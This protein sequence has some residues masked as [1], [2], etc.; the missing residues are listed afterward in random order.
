MATHSE[1]QPAYK[2]LKI[3]ADTLTPIGIFQRLHGVR[4]FLLESSFEHDKKGRYSYIGSDPYE[5]IIGYGD[6]TTIINH[7]TGAIS[8]Y[9]KNALTYLQENFPKL[10]LDLPL[11]FTGG[12]IGYI[13]YD[14]IRQF[15][16]IGTHLPDDL[17]MPDIH[18]MVYKNLI[19]YE[20]YNQTVSLV[21]INMDESNEEHLTNRLDS[22][23]KVLHREVNQSTA[24]VSDL[25]FESDLTDGDF[26]NRVQLAKDYIHQG[27]A[28]QIVLSKRMKSKITGNPLSY[29]RKLRMANPSPY[30]FYIDFKDYVIIGASPESLIQTKGTQVITNPIAGTRPRGKTKHDDAVLKAELLADKKE[31]AEHEMLVSLSKDELTQI[32]DPDSMTTPTYMNVEMYQHVMHIVSEVHGVLK[33]DQTSLDALIASLPAGTV[34]GSPKVR[35]MQIINELEDTK[36]GFYG[37]GIGYINFNHD[38]NMALAIRSLIIKADYAYLQTGAGI[39][40]DSNPEDEFHETLHKAR[41]LMEVNDIDFVL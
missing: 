5:E 24:E 28:L 29:Y 27:D 22:L 11:P 26:K 34:S 16:E 20:H 15:E 33:P 4:K 7:E 23:K 31:V 2:L 30:M 25:Q 19:I 3:N 41:S 36:R 32:C 21:S 12:A 10:D 8:E 13:G 39:V 18:F 38:L 35:A 17:N 6:T 40:H 37:G 1:S 14:A 9:P